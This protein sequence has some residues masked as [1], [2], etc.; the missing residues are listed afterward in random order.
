MKLDYL[1]TRITSNKS[2]KVTALRQTVIFIF[3]L[4]CPPKKLVKV[5][6]IMINFVT[7]LLWHKLNYYVLMAFRLRKTSTF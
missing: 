4:I 1:T 5:P 3:H 6:E 2:D 7:Q